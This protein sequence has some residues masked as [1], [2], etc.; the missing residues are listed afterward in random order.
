MDTTS[1]SGNSLRILVVLACFV[2]VVAGIRAAGAIMVPFFL[3]VFIATI[4]API[5]F[6]LKERKIPTGIAV[7][8]IFLLISILAVLLVTL[9]GS[10]I[11]EFS[12]RVPLYQKQL[13]A[14]FAGYLSWFEKF[15]IE[16]SSDIVFQYFDPGTA[17]KLAANTLT[18][19]RGIL[20]NAFFIALTVIFIL[21]EATSFPRKLAAAFN[22]SDRSL[23]QFKRITSNINRYLAIKTLTSLITGGLIAL[24][25]LFIGVDF[26]L[27][28]GMVAFLLNY[29][30]A[31]GS[32]IASVPALLLAVVQL[33]GLHVMY[34]FIG[35]LCINVI[36]GSLLEPRLFGS[37]VGLSPLVVLLS[38]IFWGWVL[39]PVGMLL[40]V[41]LTMIIKIAMEGNEETKWL[42]ILLGSD[43]PEQVA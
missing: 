40:S 33:D 4:C 32:I 25:L 7:V 39:G 21:L 1:S 8:F 15:G 34:T 43:K 12:R 2:I 42:A 30:P 36:T 20:A 6:W 31:I 10:S 24:L 16:L 27:L 17:M 19:L 9:V 22:Y 11:T 37:Q 14:N 5:L 28:W 3:S 18:R 35:Y 41:P 23:K 13:E 26:P 38:L 29:V